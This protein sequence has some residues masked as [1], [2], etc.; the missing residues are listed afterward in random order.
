M[1][2]QLTEKLVSEWAKE[3]SRLLGLKGANIEAKYI[4]NPGG[5]V[6]QSYRLS[7]GDM[8]LHVKFAREDRAACLKQWAGISGYLTENYNAPRLVHEVT[9][10]VV[11]GFHY[12]LVFEYLNGK[13][14]SP[15]SNPEPVVD[16]V[17]H[18]LKQLHRDEQIRHMIADGEA[19]TYSEA[20]AEEYITRFEEDMETIRS[21]RHMLDFVEDRTL[22]W[23]DA[24]I[25]SLRETVSEMACFQNQAIDIVHNDLNWQNILVNDESHFWII[26]WDDLSVS[27]DAAMDYSVFLWPLYGTKEWPAYKEQLIRLAGEETFERMELYI[28][29]KLLDDVIDVLADYVEAESIPDVKEA[30]QKRA[31]EIHLR[32]YPEYIR[33]YGGKG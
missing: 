13:P 21:G 28:R 12:G 20:F 14:L 25:E 33:R 26:D 22:D 7:D 32:A 19:H 5:F 23:F 18:L 1:D 10:P 3:N 16:K 9:E 30:A 8:F 6:N 17:L 15:D 2:L 29:A 31:K 24:E 27:G 4:W 11:P